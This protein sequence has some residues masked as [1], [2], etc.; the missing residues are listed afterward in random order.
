MFLKLLGNLAFISLLLA[1][2]NEAASATC[3]FGPMEGVEE[4]IKGHIT[5][6]QV[7][8]S[9]SLSINVR[10]IEGL[11]A[12]FHG[13]HIHENGDCSDPGSHFNPEGMKHGYNQDT[14]RDYHI[15]DFGNIPVIQGIHFDEELVVPG[16]LA[17]LFD[18]SPNKIIGKTYILHEL[19]D[20]LG[21]GG[22]EGSETTG[23]AGPKLGCCVITAAEE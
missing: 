4:D 1:R 17:G 23:N 22:D 18:E 7:D 15:G 10:G 13:F 16:E 20:D 21:Q 3:E 11:K 5:F 6:R 14:S 2:G 9:S 19:Q 12:G 8:A